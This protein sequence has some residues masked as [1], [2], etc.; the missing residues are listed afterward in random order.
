MKKRGA[1]KLPPGVKRTME[2]DRPRWMKDGRHV[3]GVTRVLRELGLTDDYKT[4]DPVTRERVLYRGQEVHQACHALDLGQPYD[5]IDP[6]FLPYVEGYRRFLRD[7]GFTSIFI[8]YACVDDHGRFVTVLDRAGYLGDVFVIFDIKTGKRVH[9]SARLQTAAQA[10]AFV[11]QARRDRGAEEAMHPNIRRH[12]LQLTPGDYKLHPPFS[13]GA[14][15]RA[16]FLGLLSAH[17][18][19]ARWIDVPALPDDIADAP[20]EIE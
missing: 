15:E 3:P 17:E 12:V 9:P 20:I 7:T 6:E 18:W 16:A 1:P 10:I 5:L 4:M 14:H 2:G 11:D 19:R 13:N 8:E